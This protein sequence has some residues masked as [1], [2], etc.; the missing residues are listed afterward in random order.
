MHKEIIKF[1]LSK[2]N[3][4]ILKTLIKHN[5]SLAEYVKAR[6]SSY[7][8]VAKRILPAY[9]LNEIKNMDHREILEEI[10]IIRPDIYEIL[11]TQEGF[12]WFK[13][14]KIEDFLK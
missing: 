1:L 12:K 14:Q 3:A 9:K 6:W 7:L 5:I 10:K 2:A 13:E 4:E 8:E 11:T